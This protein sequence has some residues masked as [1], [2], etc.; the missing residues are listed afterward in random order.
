MTFFRGPMAAQITSESAHK[1]HSVS[2]YPLVAALKQAE[3]FVGHNRVWTPAGAECER[4][5]QFLAFF[6]ACRRA[7]PD[8]DFCMNQ[9]GARAESGVA[10]GVRREISSSRAYVVDRP[11]Y[12]WIDPLGTIEAPP[13][14]AAYL[15]P[16]TWRGPAALTPA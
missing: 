9:Q 16:D 6:P 4:Q 11:F 14:F 8:L 5:R 2:L 1:S 12:L 10:V 15:A 13:V 3:R 7:L